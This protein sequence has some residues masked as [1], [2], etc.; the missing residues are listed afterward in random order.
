MILIPPTETIQKQ[1][2]LD[3]PGEE[4]VLVARGERQGAGPAKVDGDRVGPRLSEPVREARR[5]AAPRGARLPQPL[6][7]R[8]HRPIE[9]R[10]HLRPELRCDPRG[11]PRSPSPRTFPLPRAAELA[12]R[13]NTSVSGIGMM[14]TTTSG[15]VAG[16]ISRWC[17]CVRA[18]A[19][20]A[21]GGRR[22]GTDPH[23]TAPRG[24]RHTCRDQSS[25][26]AAHSSDAERIKT[27]RVK[28]ALA[29][30][31]LLLDKK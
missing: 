9:H 16:F 26:A 2:K 12:N 24:P 8:R 20:K 27:K 5:A 15:L 14:T 21:E 7:A 31:L 19:G 25:P 29:I 1:S 18:R 11:R 13:D 22:I 3:S 10:Q 6:R 17:W 30:S 23:G 28:I 4:G